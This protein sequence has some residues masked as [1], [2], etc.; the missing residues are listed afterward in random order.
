MKASRQLHEITPAPRTIFRA[1]RRGLGLLELCACMCCVAL[2]TLRALPELTTLRDRQAARNVAD[3]LDQQLRL[4]RL[5]AL[6]HGEN[7][8]LTVRPLTGASGHCSLVHTG[9]AVLCTCATAPDTVRC[10]APARLLY[11]SKTRLDEAG[12]TVIGVERSLLFSAKYGTVTPAATFEVRSR[13][14]Q[15]VRKIIN[16]LGRVRGCSPTGLPDMP[17]CD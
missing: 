9:A 10:E 15:R 14:G 8:R 4:A 5:L 2:L 13:K 1:R 3:A 12:A 6:S 17:A 16:V 7:M 11:S